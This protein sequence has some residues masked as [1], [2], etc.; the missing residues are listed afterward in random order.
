MTASSPPH[1]QQILW[2]C[3]LNISQMQLFCQLKWYWL[4][5]SCFSP[6]KNSYQ[7][8]LPKWLLS[9]VNL[10][11]YFTFL[12]PVSFAV[13]VPL[14]CLVVQLWLVK[15]AAHVK[16]STCL[17]RPQRLT[18]GILLTH[19]RR[20]LEGVGALSTENQFP[21]IFQNNFSVFS[22]TYTSIYDT[23]PYLYIFRVNP[24]HAIYCMPNQWECPKQTRLW[25]TFPLSVLL[26]CWH[27][28][29]ITQHYLYP[30]RFT[31]KK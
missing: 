23:I 24:L 14:I 4:L 25:R 7:K 22:F 12:K 29:F 31:N 9:H 8:F 27:T 3:Y 18:T 28:V 19:R 11:V 17:A 15:I 21:K 13:K 26:L 20:P 1:F 16:F 10:C 5:I 30:S 2:F 6:I